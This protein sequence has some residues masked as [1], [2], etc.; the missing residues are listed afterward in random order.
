MRMSFALLS[1]VFSAIS[2]VV[3]ARPAQANC[4]ENFGCTDCEY[5]AVH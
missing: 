4:Y 3:T 2:P 1:V 5:F